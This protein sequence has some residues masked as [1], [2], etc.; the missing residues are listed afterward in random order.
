MASLTDLSFK[1]TF[2]Q[3]FRIQFHLWRIKLGSG[4]G[5]LKKKQQWH[6]VN[7][8]F[9]S[10]HHFGLLSRS[11]YMYSFAK[12]NFDKKTLSL[13]M[14]VNRSKTLIGIFRGNN[15]NSGIV[16]EYSLQERDCVWCVVLWWNMQMWQKLANFA[17]HR[18]RYLSSGSGSLWEKF[19]LIQPF[20]NNFHPDPSHVNK[21]VSGSDHLIIIC[22]RIRPFDNLFASGSDHLVIICIR[23]RDRWI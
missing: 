2:N 8:S 12:E 10:H 6:R 13:I 20:N 15:N 18:I 19:I 11:I 7:H 14:L 3:S 9:A 21:F 4:S 23:I 16:W 5:I 17:M 1:N 22:I